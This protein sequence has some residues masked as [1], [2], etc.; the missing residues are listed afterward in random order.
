V[1]DTIAKNAG[2]ILAAGHSVIVDAVYGQAHE[3]TGIEAV[4]RDV[5]TAFRG[6]WLEAP[7]EV[8]E[9]RIT[10]RRADAS[11]ATVSVLHEQ[12]RVIEPARNWSGIDASGSPERCLD[13]VRRAARQAEER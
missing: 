9:L 4:A 2:K 13:L 8:L 5:G 3:R 12:S 1:Y 10:N 6:L 7:I 11:D